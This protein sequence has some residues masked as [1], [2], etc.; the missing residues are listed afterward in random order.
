[1]L[2][3]ESEQGFECL[4]TKPT[5]VELR[6]TTTTKSLIDVL[7]SNKPELFKHSG[8]YY[9][10]L[11]DH[12]L[13]YGVL[14]EKVNPNKPKV[15]TSRSYKNFDPDLFKQHLSTAPWHIGQLFDEVDDK[16]HVWNLL[17]NDIL[18]EVAPIKSMRVRDKD[19]PYMTSEWKSAIRAKRKT[20]SKYLQNKT[21][22]NWELRREA[23]NK[24]TKQRRIAIKDYWKK[25]AEDLQTNPRDFF[26]TFK[27]FLSTKDCSRNTEFQLN[28]NGTVVKD[29]K[30]VAEVLVDHFA[31][32]A[33]GIGG[34]S[35]QLKSIDDFKVHPSIQLIEQQSKN[36][37][38]NPDVKPVTQGQVHAVLKSLNTNKATGCDGI[39]AKAMQIGA[40]ELSGPL[41]TLFNSCI[42]KNVWP[43]EWKR[44]N[45]TPVYKKDD[46]HSKENYRPITVLP[47]VDKVFE[48]LIGKQV[49]MGFDDRMYN[50][51][52]AYRKA[53]SCETTLINL[54]EGW[55]QARDNKLD[56]EYTI[57]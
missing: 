21:Q 51:S 30:Q 39:P 14:K 48:Q 12:A 40:E 1:M 24:A 5:R 18:D 7:L 50:N 11:S 27:P 41:T 13:I 9:P 31:T 20:T 10:S 37:T 17:M 47:C 49:A 43:R 28:V 42:N 33:D 35:A 29:Q 46:K 8:I 44:G 6:G 2:D 26:N 16:A 54:V 56:C 22:E 32:I 19:V 4:I 36:W 55:R 25:K 15:I 34:N 57:N 23:R 3:L 52:S 53:H 45:W 38:L